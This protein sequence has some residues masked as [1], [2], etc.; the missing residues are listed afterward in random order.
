M[1]NE[2]KDYKERYKKI[3]NSKTFKLIYK[4]KSI[5]DITLIDNCTTIK[6]N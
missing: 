4:N 6:N 3:C 2:D 5:G 1:N